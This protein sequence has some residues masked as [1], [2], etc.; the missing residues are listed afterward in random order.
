MA[1]QA[2]AALKSMALCRSLAD[3]EL[4]EGDGRALAFQAEVALAG[5]RAIAAGDFAAV[6][7]KAHLAIDA[8]DVV[9]VPLAVALAQ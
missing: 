2:A 4:A 3:A 5:F 6:H 1:N 8:A 9:V 7:P